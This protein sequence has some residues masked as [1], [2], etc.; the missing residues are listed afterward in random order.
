MGNK[1]PSI[2]EEDRTTIV[3][4]GVTG[5]G[6][7]LLCNAL[8]GQRFSNVSEG[9]QSGTAGPTHCDVMRHGMALRLVD[10]VGFLSNH[11]HDEESWHWWP[12]EEARPKPA[13]KVDFEQLAPVS[14]FGVDAFLF[15]EKYGRFT[16]ESSRHFQAF[17]DLVGEAALKHTVL[18]FSHVQSDQLSEALQAPDLP[19]PLRDVIGKV[20]TVVGVE[21]LK[22]G[23]QAAATVIEA[24]RSVVKANGN[25]RYTCD[26]LRAI[27][28]RRQ[29]LLWRIEALRHSGRREALRKQ[30]KELLHGQWTYADLVRA[31]EDAEASEGARGCWACWSGLRPRPA[32][33][34]KRR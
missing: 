10:T 4:V 7:S 33:W 13:K 32:R 34:Q 31:V 30:R 24:V 28:Q 29:D 23:R 2:N 19:Q 8:A 22:A 1:A 6:K 3:C 18:V 15:V 9:F 14:I 20:H 25:E 21:T 11:C 17:V 5:V 12:P 26:E 27:Q 16:V